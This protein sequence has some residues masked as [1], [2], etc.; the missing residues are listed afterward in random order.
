LLKHKY[1]AYR[2]TRYCT[3]NFTVLKWQRRPTNCN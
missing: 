1:N 3:V 2:E